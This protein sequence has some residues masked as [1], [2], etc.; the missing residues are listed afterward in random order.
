M[1]GD[2]G[3]LIQRFNT[4][5]NGRSGNRSLMLM[6]QSGLTFP[7]IIV[8]YVLVH[9]GAQSISRIAEVT[10]LSTPATSQMVDR[11]V[12]GGY[13]SREEHAEDRRFR[14][15]ALRPKGKRLIEQ[16]HAVR[17]H[18]M[19]ETLGRLSGGLRERLRAVLT[20]VVERLETFDGG[21]PR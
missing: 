19:E 15:I 12:A 1:R 9:E 7:Q 17:H 10:K 16:L 11:L 18:E 6:H 2:L 4:I 5:V 20:D 3:G 13:V 14:V 8:L 21:R